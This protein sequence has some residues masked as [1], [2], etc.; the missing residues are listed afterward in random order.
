MKYRVVALELVP[1]VVSELVVSKKG[2]ISTPVTISLL[3]LCRFKDFNSYL[4]SLAEF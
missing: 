1:R 4:V 2:E 3:L